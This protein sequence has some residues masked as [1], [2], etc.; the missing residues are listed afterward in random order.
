[1]KTKLDDFS[2]WIVCAK[3]EISVLVN[4]H[5]FLLLLL[6]LQRWHTFEYLIIITW[7]Q[8]III[9]KYQVIVTCPGS[10]KSASSIIKYV[11]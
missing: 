10:D 8:Q 5:A 11:W 2:K 3:Q 7:I 6:L 4:F 9:I 1:M